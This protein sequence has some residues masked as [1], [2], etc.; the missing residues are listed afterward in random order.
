MAGIYI[1][2]PFC[3][4]ACHYCNFHFS[5]TFESYRI[6]LIKSLQKEII[7]RKDFFGTTSQ[8]VNSVYFGGGTPSLLH[9]QELNE[10]MGVIWST[11]NID[12]DAEVTLEANPDDL[13]KE[14]LSFLRDTPV[15]RLSIGIQ[16]FNQDDLR[17]LNRAHD[18]QQ[19]IRSLKMAAMMGFP[20]VSADLIFGIPTSSVK[21]LE[22]DARLFAD[23]GVE[24]I[25][26]YGLTIE[27]KTALERLIHLKKTKSADE[28]Q[29]AIEMEWLMDYLPSIGYHQYEISNYSIPGAEARHNSSYWEGKPYLGIGPSAHSYKAPVRSWNISNNM[30]YIKGLSADENISISE[31]LTTADAYNEYVMTSLRTSKGAC[32]LHIQQQFGETYLNYFSNHIHQLVEDGRAIRQDNRIVLTKYGK[33]FCDL[34]S[35]SLFYIA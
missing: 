23:L 1:H 30:S 31:E 22:H 2:I 6:P 26:A 10:I 24:H 9:Q 19:A 12:A 3:K 29:S 15:N 11:F 5:T 34:I 17:Y 27:P 21:R 32:S 8:R 16:S 33:L 18:K 28:L 35:Q 20:A 7:Q 13:S 14:Y 25:S 4:Q